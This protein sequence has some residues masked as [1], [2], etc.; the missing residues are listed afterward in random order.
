M[1]SSDYRDPEA[2]L[3][4]VSESWWQR[5]LGAYGDAVAESGRIHKRDT[6]AQVGQVKAATGSLFRPLT[7]W[8]QGV[9]P[10]FGI[11][12]FL[13]VLLVLGL[14]GLLLGSGAGRALTKR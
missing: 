7:D 2:E 13:G 11:Y 9:A 6:E 3:S 14:A 5:S 12:T 4:L 10:V 8:L 1:L